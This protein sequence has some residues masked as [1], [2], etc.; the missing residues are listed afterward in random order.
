MGGINMTV[1]TKE[2]VQKALNDKGVKAM[3]CT[4]CQCDTWSVNIDL[5][6]KTPID[7]NSQIQIGKG[8]ITPTIELI[9]NNCGHVESFDPRYLK[10][11]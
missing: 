8:E 9:C 3:R 10:Q 4:I 2:E 7:E 1:M 5:S 6:A 11:K